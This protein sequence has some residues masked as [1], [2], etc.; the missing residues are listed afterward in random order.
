M[1]DYWNVFTNLLW[2][3]GAATVLATASAADWQVSGGAGKR[4]AMVRRVAQSPGFYAGMIMVCLGA[5]LGAYS[6]GERI[7]WFLLL[8]IF[9]SQAGWIGI[10]RWK[11]ARP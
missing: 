11:K 5:S 9:A 6:W 3:A 2:I 8:M 1:I 7:G 4:W 10:R